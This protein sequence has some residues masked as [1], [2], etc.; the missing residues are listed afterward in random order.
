MPSWSIALG[1]LYVKRSFSS[2]RATGCLVAVCI[3]FF[4]L[5]VSSVSATTQEKP[6]KSDVAVEF[7]VF[8]PNHDSEADSIYCSMSIMFM[9]MR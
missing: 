6:K 2:L 5:N 7:V 3:A 4:G 1:R 8:T 9:S